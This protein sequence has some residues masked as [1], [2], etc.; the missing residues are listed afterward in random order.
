[1][2]PNSETES[3]IDNLY[4]SFNLKYEPVKTIKIFGFSLSGLIFLLLIIPLFID[5]KY[6]I[7]RE[8]TIQRPLEEVFGY[9]KY[10]KNQDNFSV[11][12]KIDPNMKKEYTGTDGTVG[13]VSAWD[14]ENKDAGKGEQKI[15]NLIENKQI[16][17]ELHFI[18]PF[19]STD[20]AYMTT[21]AVNDS[22]TTVKW[23]MKGEMKYPMNM[24]LLFMDMEKM[25]A[26]DFENGLSNLKSILEQKQ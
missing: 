23:G 7:E 18:K 15:V 11:W 10:L 13:F 8:V 19:E 25:L 21:A 1:M 5:G 22:V 3:K 20:Q 17:Y 14:S 6:S 16:D 4:F 12:A 26:P 24:M 2:K 9:I